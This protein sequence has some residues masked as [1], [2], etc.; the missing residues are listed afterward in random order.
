[1]TAEQQHHHDQYAR[2]CGLDPAAVV[3]CPVA[4]EAVEASGIALFHRVRGNWEA[5]LDPDQILMFAALKIKGG[6][7]VGITEAKEIARR[8]RQGNYA[9]PWR[10]GLVESA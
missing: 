1:M 8:L 5:V 10:P 6:G 9:W 2:A 4:V 3:F 7:A